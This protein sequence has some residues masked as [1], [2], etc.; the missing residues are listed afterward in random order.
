MRVRHLEQ[1]VQG[2][3]GLKPRYAAPLDYAALYAEPLGTC[4]LNGYARRRLTRACVGVGH[5]ARELCYLGRAC[6]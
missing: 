5:F 4:S 3:Y 6:L 1:A 2:L